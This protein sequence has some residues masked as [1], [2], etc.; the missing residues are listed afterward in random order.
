MTNFQHC[1]GSTIHTI[2]YEYTDNG[3]TPNDNGGFSLPDYIEINLNI[4]ADNELPRGKIQLIIEKCR[5]D[6]HAVIEL[7]HIE[8]SIDAVKSFL[9][10]EYNDITDT[11]PLI[12]YYDTQINVTRRSHGIERQTQFKILD[13]IKTDIN[14]K[15]DA[16]RDRY[17]DVNTRHLNTSTEFKS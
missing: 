14:G 10:S 3:S 4:T 13:L 15:F 11:L 7:N 9:H 12:E 6:I 2:K 5:D 17:L 8:K 16:I 1:D